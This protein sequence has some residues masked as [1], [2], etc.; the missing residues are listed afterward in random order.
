MGYLLVVKECRGRILSTKHYEVGCGWFQRN[1]GIIVPILGRVGTL[2]GVAVVKILS[3]ECD[4]T[5]ASVVGGCVCVCVCEGC[6]EKRVLMMN[7]GCCAA[8]MGPREIGSAS[9]I[10][11]RRLLSLALSRGWDG[12]G[13]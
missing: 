6:A 2:S 4:Y 3:K 13:R 1:V 7:P 12:R 5:I 9:C 10:L 8:A 11:R